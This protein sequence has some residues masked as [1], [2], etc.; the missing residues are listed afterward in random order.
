[1]NNQLIKLY[2]AGRLT[3]FLLLAMT[4]LQ[5]STPE[6]KEQKKIQD[7]I[8]RMTLQQKAE[9]VVGTGMDWY[10]PEGVPDSLLG[11]L[12]MMMRIPQGFDS[13]YIAAVNKLRT[14]CPGSSGNTMEFPELGITSMVLSDGPAGLRI[15]PER[16]G[17]EGT[18]YSTAF[19]IGTN[20][21]STWDTQL[22]NEIGKAMGN[23]VLEYN[24]DIILGPGL[25][26]QRDPLCGRNFEYYSED[27][28]VT[29]KM[30]AAII[31]GVQ[32]NGVGNSAKHFAANNQETNRF[33]VNTIVSERALRELYLRGFE[34]AVK[35]A[36]PLTVMSSYNLINGTYASES[37]DLL[38]KVLRDDW[39]FKGY[40]VTDWGGGSDAAAQMKAGNDMIQPG[41]GQALEI[42]KAVENGD[43]DIAV[44]DKNIARILSVMF[45]LPKYRNYQASNRPDL[46]A[47][48]GV[49]RRAAAEGMVLLKNDGM[50]LP[51][52][53]DISK[54]ALFG[55]T[56]YELISGG[57]GSGDV[58]EA[59][60]ISLPE[61]LKA[62][63]LNPD[64]TLAKTYSDYAAAE[65]AKNPVNSNRL[66]AAMGVRSQVKEM[67]VTASLANKAAADADAAIITIGRNSG[68]GA[69]RTA[70][71]G[72]FYLTDLEKSMIKTVSSAFREVGKKAVVVLNIGGV[73]ATNEW[74][75]YPD[76]ILCAWQGGQ[77]AGNSIVDVLK[78]TVNPSGKLAITF[79]IKYEDAPSASTFPGHLDETVTNA[80][81]EAEA[82]FMGSRLPWE[83]MY[84][85]DIFVGYRYYNTF[86]IPVA[87]EFGFGLSYTKFEYSNALI[88]SSEFTD[89]VTVTID[90]TNI[91]DVAGKEVVQVYLKAPAEKMEKPSMALVSFGK[92][93]LLAPGETQTLSFDLMPR[94]LC[95]FDAATSSWVAEAGSYEVMIGSSSRNIQAV[96]SFKLID[97]TVVETVSRALVPQVEIKKQYS[98]ANI[99]R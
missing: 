61:A 63:S 60:T 93:K 97:E 83:V 54:V 19:P 23:E 66:A 20:L 36:Q 71:A 64:E 89:H 57:T 75:D 79:P 13:S 68:E 86:N 12:L 76:A 14:N 29:G 94:D 37:H 77:E 25:N 59:Y 32:S 85:E 6:K 1:M 70:T 28:L 43:L 48:A 95:S 15:A 39:G 45:K 5:C 82:A 16:K 8:S 33:T 88:S 65:R 99:Q 81:P 7:I 3:M 2:R 58:N 73:I 56:S 98:T 27:P 41:P 42:I 87:Y 4:L 9:L 69:D 91:G 35:E 24:S 40:V 72:D 38:T 31:N 30:A 52:G 50:A 84:T 17:E 62:N 44:L 10:V 34:I 26:L 46:Q 49:T 51:L 67:N 90:V 22:V 53:S 92:T 80:D 11:N 55:I 18:F 74:R 21:A 78:G 96:V 47:H